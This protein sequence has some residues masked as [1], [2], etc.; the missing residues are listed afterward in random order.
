[1]EKF[2][3]KNR[4]FSHHRAKG[5]AVMLPP[6]CPSNPK[7]TNNQTDNHCPPR[8]A[9]RCCRLRRPAPA[10]ASWP[11]AALQTTVP[12]SPHQR[13]ASAPPQ[14]V[15]GSDA[16]TGAAALAE[17]ATAQPPGSA[18]ERRWVV[19]VGGVKRCGA[20]RFRVQAP[21]LPIG[22]P[23]WHTPWHLLPCPPLPSSPTPPLSPPQAAPR[24]AVAADRPARAAPPAAVAG[25]AADACIPAVL[26]AGAQPEA[27]SALAAM[28]SVGE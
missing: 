7:Q 26:P 18:A 5:C 16:S 12:A 27:I 3:G 23:L 28:E 15:A 17:L 22:T 13:P 10:P 6:T 8:P 4:L 11:S 21:N 2:N 9:Q 25:T 24:G 1:M 14:C 20:P 19:G